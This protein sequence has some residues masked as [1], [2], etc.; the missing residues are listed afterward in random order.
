M[1]IGVI[2]KKKLSLYRVGGEQGGGL[3]LCVRGSLLH[4]GG[5]WTDLNIEIRLKLE[6]RNS[7]RMW[8]PDIDKQR[9]NHHQRELR[10]LLKKKTMQGIQTVGQGSNHVSLFVPTISLRNVTRSLAV[11][12]IRL[13]IYKPDAYQVL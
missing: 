5:S 10:Q 2:D 8:R 11:P 6:R 1:S 9:R 7:T 3:N 13:S 12:N 4:R